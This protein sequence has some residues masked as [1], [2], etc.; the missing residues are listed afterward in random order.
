MRCLYIPVLAI[1]LAVGCSP[2]DPVEQ[3]AVSFTESDLRAA[4]DSLDATIQATRAQLERV[5]PLDNEEQRR[6]RDRPYRPSYSAHLAAGRR[7][8][9]APISSDAALQRLIAAERL[10]PLVDTEFYT[11]V[12]LEHSAPF[13][14]PATVAALEETG[15]RFQTRLRERGLPPFRFTISSALRTGASQADLRK[16]NRNAAPGTSSHEYG[17]CIDLVYT[18]Y[19]YHPTPPAPEAGLLEAFVHEARERETALLAGVYWR[20]LAGLL[21]RVLAEMQ[22][23]GTWLVLL[24]ERQPVYHITL[25][26]PVGGA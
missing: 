1:A 14:T 7:L 9:V 12:V 25:G 5:R 22:A 10:V 15:R 16:V 17:T 26:A 21:G 18:R 20:H 3:G 24:E 13:V 2:A 4:L 8:G 6:L 23:E 11:V 19:F